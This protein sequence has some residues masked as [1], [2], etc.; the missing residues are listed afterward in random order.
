MNVIKEEIQ[1]IK[2]TDKDLRSFSHVVGGIFTALGLLFW[3][4]HHHLYPYFL[5]A[6][7]FLLIV[8]LVALRTLRPLYKA[9]MTLSILMGFVV[10]RILL[11]VIFYL[12]ITPLALIARLVGKKFLDLRFRTDEKSYWISKEDDTRPLSRYEN[13]F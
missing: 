4:K 7:L 13:Q 1:N 5:G 11:S 8:G 6:G 3:W 10:S 12:L 2:E 9:W